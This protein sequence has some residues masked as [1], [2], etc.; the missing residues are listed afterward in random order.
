MKDVL[1]DTVYARFAAYN[2]LV[3]AIYLI[4]TR[5]AQIILANR[6]GLQQ[7]QIGSMAELRRTS[8][9]DLQS[10]VLDLAHW[11][12]IVEV[13]RQSPP[14]VFLGRHLR[15]D[16]SEFAVEVVSQIVNWADREYVLS[17]VRDLSQRKVLEDNMHRREPLLS[18]VLNEASDGLWDWNVAT[19][20]MFF[21][22]QL[23]RMLGYGPFEM[24]PTID[25]WGKSVH[26]DDMESVQM[27]LDHHFQGKASRYEAEYR[28]ANRNGD[29]LWVQDKGRVCQTD[30]DGQPL[31]VIGVVHNIDKQKQM[32]QRLRELATH[33]E[34]TG[35][36][37]RRAGYDAFKL[38]L[39][40]C[41]RHG[42]PLSV[43][44][45]D[46]DH[47]KQINDQLGHFS[48]DRVLAV[49]GELLSQ[50][51]RA[52][53]VLMR[54]GGEEFLLVMPHTPADAA[55]KLCEKLLNVIREEP[56][57]LPDKRITVTMS[58]GVANFPEHG[59]NMEQLVQSADV[60]MYEAKTRGRKC[61]VQAVKLTI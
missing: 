11:Q 4:D 3:D 10:D 56:V 9:F 21:S 44:L 34:L 39:D 23:A 59:V 14:Y 27:A 50:C 6:A 19:G 54:W 57:Q 35:L 55:F 42:H 24:E 46:L 49:V 38:T 13:V 45:F 22:P 28:L 53:D 12:K 52:S 60:A 5:T 8:V 25:T 58:G 18:Y 43:A 1:D 29:Y 26:S 40:L 33:D 15:K 2:H 47:F 51:V 20:E 31:R 17:E 16:G 41:S 37:N 7:V 36:M 61:V 30:T 32:E 48:G